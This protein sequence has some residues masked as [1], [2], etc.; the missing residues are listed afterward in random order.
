MHYKPSRFAVSPRAGIAKQ[1]WRLDILN[2][3]K[4]QHNTAK[5]M[6]DSK[7]LVIKINYQNKPGAFSE[8]DSHN[9]PYITVWNI[10]R[11]AGAVAALSLLIALGGYLWINKGGDAETHNVAAITAVP[12]NAISAAPQAEATAALPAPLPATADNAAE[13]NLVPNNSDETPKITP[14]SKGGVVRGS[15]AK[16]I[17]H[18]EPH[19]EVPLSLPLGKRGKRT[20]Y[21]FTELQNMSGKTIYHEWLYNGKSVFKRPVKITNQRWRT[22]THKIIHSTALG[23]WCVRVVDEDGEILHRID[24][25][26]VAANNSLAK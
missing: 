1:Q 9:I 21:Y 17:R 11:I 16:Y 10:K 15:L 8:T 20:I 18:K 25:K 3:C 12:A 26:V 24:F 5:A 4:T 7:K 19:G 2:N 14:V 6:T 23:A 22:S 13:H